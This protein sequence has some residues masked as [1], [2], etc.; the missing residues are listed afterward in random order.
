MDEVQTGLG[1]TVI[2]AN[3]NQWDAESQYIY[4]YIYIYIL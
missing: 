1:R 2:N 3:C 4:I